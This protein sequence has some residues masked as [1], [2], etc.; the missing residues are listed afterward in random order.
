MALSDGEP[1]SLGNSRMDS[2]NFPF[3]NR[4]SSMSE[5]V[6]LFNARPL[7]AATIQ[8][9]Q[10]F[11]T[12]DK[13]EATKSLLI[14]V[15]AKDIA[16]KSDDSKETESSDCEVCD[17]EFEETGVEPA[18]N[19]ND[20]HL[21]PPRKKNR[22]SLKERFLISAFRSNSNG[23]H[24]RAKGSSLL[25]SLRKSVSPSSVRL[26]LSDN[27]EML[28]KFTEVDDETIDN[29]YLLK[30]Q[31]DEFMFT[32]SGNDS[33]DHCREILDELIKTEKNY[34]D[35]LENL[36][37]HFVLGLRAHCELPFETPILTEDEIRRCFLNVYELLQLNKQL[38]GEFKG[39]IIPLIKNCFFLL[40]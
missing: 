6:A 20:E 1:P 7:V 35:G 29:E 21:R 14:P 19:E 27:P 4:S 5:S 37:C 26:P 39:I 22:T 31:E 16:A 18:H 38:L 36:H 12:E 32:F 15:E 3:Q 30:F 17:S 40:T 13:P 2:L 33:S 10:N 34:V 25:S 11:T 28:S 9:Q 24:A 8:S 23:S